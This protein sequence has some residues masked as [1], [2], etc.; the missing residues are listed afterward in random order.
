MSKKK[1]TTAQTKTQPQS[2]DPNAAHPYLHG[3]N[4][5]I[6]TVTHH[7]TGRLI[8]VYGLNCC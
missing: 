5:F 1:E 3:R 2:I 6:R 4:Y 7:L 8:G